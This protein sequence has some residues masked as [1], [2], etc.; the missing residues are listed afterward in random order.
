MAN[1]TYIPAFQASVGDWTYYICVMK[2]AEVKR[3][4]GFAHELGGNKDLNTMIQ[5]GISARTDDI[6]DYLLSSEHRFLGSLIVAAWGGD[7]NYTDLEM[8]DPEGL[9]EGLDSG[10]GV[11]TFDGTQQYF[12]LDGQHRLT[13]IRE[14]L[15]KDP[16]LGNDDISV[17]MVPHYDTD[18]GRERTRRLFTNINRNAKTTTKSENIALDVDDGFAIVT[19]RLLQEHDFLSQTGRVRVFTRP[20]TDSGEMVL[21]GASVPKTDKAAWTT[22][23]VLYDMVARLAADLPSELHDAASR[24]SDQVLEDAYNELSKRLDAVMHHCGGLRKRLEQASNAR[25]VRAPKDQEGTGHPLMRPVVQKAVCEALRQLLEH[26]DHD[27]EDGTKGLAKL[28]WRMDSAPWTAVFNPA[29][30]RMLTAKENRDL[31]LELLMAHL[32]PASKKAVERAR[33]HYR[34]IKGEQYSYSIEDLQPSGG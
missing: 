11:L 10:F 23:T 21:A 12:A 2:Y 6:R 19:R 25:D 18:E 27:F 17:L 22:I 34:E 31:L 30:S 8:S 4:V 1:K 33:K 3:Q 28:T 29:N 14:A 13:A 5:R 32:A 15:L 26:G 7:P 24:P 9:L 16:G 20:P